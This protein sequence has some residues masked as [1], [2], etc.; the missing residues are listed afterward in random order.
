MPYLPHRPW[1]LSSQVHSA[2]A[3][4]SNASDS[5]PVQL[6]SQSSL[7]LYVYIDAICSEVPYKVK[8]H[9]ESTS[10]L[11]AQLAPASLQKEKRT[12]SRYLAHPEK[13]VKLRRSVGWLSIMRISMIPLVI[14]WSGR[15]R[16]LFG[17]VLAWV[18]LNQRQSHVP[19]LPFQKLPPYHPLR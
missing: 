7:S 8:N 2:K 18:P 5:I 17:V 12:F 16:S 1:L 9:K 15:V 19:T 4:Y 3:F 11:P 6:M 10:G 14:K 13:Y